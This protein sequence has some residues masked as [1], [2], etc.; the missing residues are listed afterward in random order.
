MRVTRKSDGVHVEKAFDM[1]YT[2]TETFRRLDEAYPGV[3]ECE[4]SVLRGAPYVSPEEIERE[5]VL[6]DGGLLSDAKRIP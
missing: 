6:F 3:Y 5:F 2:A 4:L 1:D